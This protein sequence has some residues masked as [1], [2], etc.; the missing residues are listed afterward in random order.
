MKIL[1]LE[2]SSS[3]R[4]AAVLAFGSDDLSESRGD[5]LESG[6]RAVGAFAMID[7]AL[8][9]AQLERNRSSVL[10]PALALALTRNWG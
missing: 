6:P 7:S 8:K 4:S 1:A 10:Q 9:Q 3:E 5:A 2:F